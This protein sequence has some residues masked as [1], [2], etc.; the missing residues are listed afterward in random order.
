MNKIIIF[1]LMIIILVGSVVC[2]KKNSTNSE[3]VTITDLLP[4]DNEISGWSRTGNSWW[5]TSSG[6]LNQYI[7]GEEPDY[8]RHGFVKGAM[9]TYAGSVL[10]NTASVEVRVFDQQSEENAQ[11]LFQELSARLINPLDWSGAGDDAK[12]ERFSLSQKIIFEK[13]NYFISLTIDSGLD[14]ALNVLKTFAT[15]VSTKIS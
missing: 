2:S 10:E 9:Q 5:A 1:F 15:N 3:V 4:K 13:S 6:E 11:A 8:T 14:E 7:N 12:I